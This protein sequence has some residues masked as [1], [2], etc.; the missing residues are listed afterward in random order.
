[1]AFLAAVQGYQL[2]VARLRVPAV[3]L[4]GVVLVV[5]AVTTGLAY[6]L[7]PRLARNGRP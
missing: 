1:M 5:G 4:L 6:A 7:E 2:A 3:G